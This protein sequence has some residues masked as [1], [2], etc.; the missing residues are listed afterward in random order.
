MKNIRPLLIFFFIN[1]CT[2]SAVWAGGNHLL[3]L[4]QKYVPLHTYFNLDKVTLSTPVLQQEWEDLVLEMGG[5]IAAKAS[6][7]I[8]V[9]LLASLPEVPL[10]QDEAYKLKV[11]KRHLLSM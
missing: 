1:L 2:I 8:E 3:P 5:T 7:S 11:T 6:C 9:K 10:N 4:P